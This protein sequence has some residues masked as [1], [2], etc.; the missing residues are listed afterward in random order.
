MGPDLITPDE[1]P[2][3][4]PGQ[5]TVRNPDDGWRGL[6]VRG[7]RYSGSDVQV[8]PVRDYTIVAYHRGRTD[9]SRQIDGDWSE[10]ALGPGDVSLM[11]RAADS[12]WTWS[13]DIE[14]SLIF[15]SQEE[16]AETCR[17]M[18]DREVA[19][20]DLRDVLK[21]DDPAIYRTAAQIAAEAAQ[22]DLGSQLMVDS[23]SCQMAVHLLRRHSQI[24]F[25]EPGM[26][27]CLTFRQIRLVRDY[28]R[29][30]I[31]ENIG[32]DDLAGSI[33]LSRFH[34]AR[35]FRNTTG[36]TPHEFVVQQRIAHARTLLRRTGLALREIA[37]AC[38]FA[39]QSHMTRIFRRRLGVTPGRYRYER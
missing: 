33:A 27:D 37:S 5:L 22:G 18:Y 38:G 17:Q 21:A 19:D 2:I 12:R 24:R 6:S 26:N 9:M 30:H 25:R 3:W 32:L 1:V 4:V 36:T 34:F 8:P 28:I 10:D 35:Q 31:H 23:L 39:D 13:Q 20:V 15:L 29:D 16:V 11:T 7:F 14:V